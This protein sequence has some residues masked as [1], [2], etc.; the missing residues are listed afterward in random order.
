MLPERRNV[1]M[2]ILYLYHDL[3]NLYGDNGNVRAMQRHLTDQGFDVEV[4]KRSV[5]DD[6]DLSEYAFIYCG[7]GAEKNR[8]VALLQ[9]MQ[10]REGLREVVESGAVALFTGNSLEMLGERIEST[11]GNTYEALG[12]LP[13]HVKEHSDK[14]YTGDAVFECDELESPM[15]GFVNKCSELLGISMEHALFRVKMGMGNDEKSD[16]EGI[17]IHNLFGTYLTGPVCVKNPHFMEYLIKLIGQRERSGFIYTDR[18]SEYEKKSY[19]V[20]LDA[21]QERMR[22]EK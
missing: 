16:R 13:F 10:F 4:E 22:S 15:V 21:L 1:D 8:N 2:K 14:R 6:L 11:D 19:K 7:S 12:L 3:M 5:G 9:L 17:R 20:T 18:N